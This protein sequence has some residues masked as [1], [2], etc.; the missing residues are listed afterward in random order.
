M[1]TLNL[2]D[3]ERLAGGGCQVPGC[4]HPHSGALYVHARCHLGAGNEVSYVLGSGV[5]R[6]ACRVCKKVIAEV[7][8][9]PEVP[10]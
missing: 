4:T 2:E 10:P 5:L 7:A 6:I 8:V 3:L 9:A 1:A